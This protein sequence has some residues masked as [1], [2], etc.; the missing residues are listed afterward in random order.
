MYFILVTCLVKNQQCILYF[1]KL[2]GRSG[3]HW[4][5]KIVIVNIT[6]GATFAIG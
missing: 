3:G 2:V 6:I 5:R 1:K 4:G